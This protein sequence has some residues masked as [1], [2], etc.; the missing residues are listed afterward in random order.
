MIVRFALAQ[1]FQ[2]RPH[3]WEDR[4]RKAGR[5][6][7]PKSYDA[8]C[9]QIDIAA[10]QRTGL[11]LAESRQ[12]EKLQKV[13]AVLRVCV[14]NLGTHVANDCFELLKTRRQSNWFLSF[15]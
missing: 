8:A 11:S 9:F 4:N 15:G 6:L 7:V 2:Q 3:L 10:A 14:E 13:S 1:C 5:R 12:S